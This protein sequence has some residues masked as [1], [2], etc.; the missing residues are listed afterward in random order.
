MSMHQCNYWR[1]LTTAF[2]FR[3]QQVLPEG[4]RPL[5]LLLPSL[6]SQNQLQRSS[7][8]LRGYTRS[9]DFLCYPGA[10]LWQAH[11][12]PGKGAAKMSKQSLRSGHWDEESQRDR[13]NIVE[14][15]VSLKPV[16]ISSSCIYK[17]RGGVSVMLQEHKS[18]VCIFKEN[19]VEVGSMVYRG[20]LWCAITLQNISLH[21]VCRYWEQ[22]GGFS[23]IVY[24]FSMR[25]HYL[26]Y[27]LGTYSVLIQ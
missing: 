10:P 5:S 24:E 12:S 4:H 14:G 15:C 22:P 1:V 17:A 19:R 26:L 25:P 21:N 9:W 27:A 18:I 6:S 3:I 20:G 2:N 13:K 11:G 23:V 7:P 16:C 8:G